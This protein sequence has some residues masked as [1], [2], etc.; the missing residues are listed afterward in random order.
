MR[1]P[2]HQTYCEE[3]QLDEKHGD[4]P[5]G[6]NTLGYRYRMSALTENPPVV[7]GMF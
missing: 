3:T 5:S 7:L 4:L 6:K 2:M 1:G